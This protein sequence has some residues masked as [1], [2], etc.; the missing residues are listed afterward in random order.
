METN[1]IIEVRGLKFERTENGIKTLYRKFGRQIVEGEQEAKEILAEAIKEALEAD[2]ASVNKMYGLKV[3]LIDTHKAMSY[4]MVARVKTDNKDHE[5]FM[6]EDYP[7][8]IEVLSNGAEIRF[9]GVSTGLP[10]DFEG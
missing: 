7:E 6:L 3:S 4:S 9:G 10:E 2:P 1:K 8:L 5:R